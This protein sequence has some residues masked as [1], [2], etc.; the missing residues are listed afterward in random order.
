MPRPRLPF[1]HRETTR[2]GKTVWYFRRSEGAKRI[3]LPDDY[4][5]KEFQRVYAQALAGKL[6]TPKQ[7]EQNTLAWAV[8]RYK[9]TAHWRDLDEVTKRRRDSIFRSMCQRSGDAP[10][11]AVTNRHIIAAMDERADKR[12]AANNFLK[13]IRPVFANA[14][15]NGWID[16]DPTAGVKQIREQTDGFHTWT[17][18][19][20]EA[21]EARHPI[22]T[23]ARLAFDLMLYTGL[24]RSDVVRVGRQ[25]IRGGVLT[26]RPAKTRETSNVVVNIRILPPLAASIAATKTGDLTLIVTEH[27]KAFT[28]A[29]FGN[30][31]GDCCRAAGVPGAA[32]GLRKAA[33]TRAAENGA[34]TNELMAMFGWTTSDQAEL[35][36]KA[37]DRKRMGIAASDKLNFRTE[38]PGAGASANNE[39]KSIG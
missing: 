12:E 34:T 16:T 14:V 37:A 15:K 27:G 21:F 6:D 35:Y 25:H 1:V 28:P 30:W 31:F 36:T 18:E 9:D 20:V 5:S 29:G 2:H 39:D 4:G 33:A 19:E 24:R 32:H 22:G 23:R 8:E 10:L 7:P 13:A 38:E 11:S 17:M 3:R 26:I